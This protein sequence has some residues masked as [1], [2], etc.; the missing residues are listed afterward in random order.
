MHVAESAGV[1]E[2]PLRPEPP[3][4]LAVAARPGL[5]G[6]LVRLIR[7]LHSIKA[8]LLI[9]I[10]LID[11]SPWTF[12]VVGRV[13]WAAL[14]FVLASA[15]VYVGN[16]IADRHRDR[17]H[18]VKRRRPVA[19]GRVPVWGACLYCAVLLAL[20]AVVTGM[21]TGPY[22]PVAAYLV[23][24]VAYIRVLKH[25]P[26]VDVGAVALGFVLRVVQ[27]YL[28]TG[29]RVAGWL[30]ITAFSVSLLLLI[31]KRR[32]ELLG[33]GAAHRPA[34]AGYS[35]ELANALLQITSVLALVAGLIYLRTEAPFGPDH[36]Q[37]AMMLSV[38]FA[39]FA[40]FRYLQIQLAGRGG[41]DPVRVLLRD[42]VTV[43][44]CGLWAAVLGATL[45]LVHYPVLAH[46]ILP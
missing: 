31:G 10:A 14:A 15:A 1:H 2:G 44:I 23:L 11:A 4:G 28:A 39:L 21:G 43:G 22:W 29:E 41:T 42:R 6:D 20:L 24:N 37:T 45:A 36:G 19:A 17:R 40:L 32:Q 3:P 9:P 46:A 38:P 26:L 13:A 35:L 34:L 8:L 25:I 7:P 12:A 16:D 27:G 30:L 5:A 18:P 33:V